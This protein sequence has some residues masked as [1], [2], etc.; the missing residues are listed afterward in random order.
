M[1]AKYPVP[2]TPLANGKAIIQPKPR[3]PR[4]FDERCANIF[5]TDH[6]FNAFRAAVTTS[7]AQKVVPVDQQYALAKKIMSTTHTGKKG[8]GAPYIKR[9]VQGEVEENLKKQRE[10]DKEERERYLAEQQE[11]RI[12]SELHDANRQLRGLRSCIARLIDLAGDFP[13][14]PKIGG[15]SAQ[16]DRLVI[17]I[18][19]LSKKLK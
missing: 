13:H 4:V 2:D 17:A 14:H 6:Q 7:G 18:Q 15:F 19:Q 12:E 16:L 1:R 3:R 8:V 9:M 5:P 10:I 11:E